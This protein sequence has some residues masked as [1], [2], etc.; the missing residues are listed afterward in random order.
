[1]YSTTDK[2]NLEGGVRER[3]K[4]EQTAP[5]DGQ[6][7]EFSPLSRKPGHQQQQQPERFL[8]MNLSVMILRSLRMQR[9]V[10]PHLAPMLVSLQSQPVSVLALSFWLPGSSS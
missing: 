6:P 7:P 10:R 5:T 4:Q 1:M 3:E 8:S 9:P 2:S